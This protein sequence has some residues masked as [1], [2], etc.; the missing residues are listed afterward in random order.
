LQGAFVTSAVFVLALA[1][2]RPLDAAGDLAIAPA[3]FKFVA[4]QSG[5]TNYYSVEREGE[6]AF[7][8][9]RYAPPMKTA[10]VGWQAPE[11]ERQTARRLKWTWRAQTLP[12]GG[13]ECAPGKGD[14]AAVVYLTWK[15]GLRYYTLKYVW[16]AV[17]TKGR[18]CDSKR[19]PF[20][21][22]DTVILESGPPLNTWRSAD[23]DLKAEF[24]RH[25]EDGDPNAS[26]PDFVGIGL[27]SDGDQTQSASSADFGPFT[28]VR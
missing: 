2:V 26:V 17:G 9:S 16:S 20:V 11:A 14:S 6:L 1:L 19:N 21:A 12:V 10:L 5:P 8:R 24:R 13:D 23:V 7:V 28:L 25:F 15:R 22:Q 27:M 3:A 18:T 4:K